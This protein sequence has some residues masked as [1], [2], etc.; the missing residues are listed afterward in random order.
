MTVTIP[1]LGK[2]INV[3]VDWLT[4]GRVDVPALGRRCTFLVDGFEPAETSQLSDCVQ[5]FCG[6]SAVDLRRK[7][8]DHVWAYYRD[9]A[10]HYAHEP[11][12]PVIAGIESVWDYVTFGAEIWVKQQ[13]SHW[14]VSVENECAWE[15][16][17]GLELVF[18][19][20]RHLVKVG[21]VDG[22]LTNQ[23][24]YNDDSI[25][26]EIVYRSQF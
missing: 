24:A 13:E 9:F 10:D 3:E 4:S 7:A 22:H 26:E 12:F 6:L 14:Y 18:K 17:H 11:G 15:P 25:P 16:E 2:L 8:G 23:W 1:G 21:Q 20:G 5:A 19:D